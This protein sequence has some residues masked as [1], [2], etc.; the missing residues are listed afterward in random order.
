MLR[1][2]KVLPK[3]GYAAAVDTVT[4]DHDSRF[5][6]RIALTGAKGTG[7]LLDLPEAVALR[8]GD[9]LEL[10]DG[11]VV[12]VRAADEDLMEITATDAHHLMRLAWHIGNR[13]LPAAIEADRILIRPDH[14]IAEMIEGLGGRVHAV[15][16]PFDPEGGAYAHGAHDHE[17]DHAHAHHY[18]DGDGDG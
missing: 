18:H 8:D 11:R 5:R 17:H 13:H 3:G 4:L 2:L 16:A 10:E 6:R 9:G 1:A 14:V 15:R 7:F 12:I